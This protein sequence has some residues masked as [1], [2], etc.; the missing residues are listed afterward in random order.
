MRRNA[1]LFPSPGEIEFDCSCPDWA[2]M[3]KHIAA[4]LY[5][6][7]ARLDEDPTL[8]FTLRGV[9]TGDLIK[10]TVSS[11]AED[12]LRKV[13]RKS[14][15]IIEGADLSAAF[16]IEL[17]EETGTSPED[18]PAQVVLVDGRVR[19]AR[20]EKAGKNREQKNAASA[21][22]VK[23]PR[24]AAAKKNGVKRKA[25]AAVKAASKKQAAVRRSKR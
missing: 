2:S 21:Q 25:K 7:G 12:L 24:K 17:A 4:T 9:D 14:F 11:K 20:T 8:F 5:G 6:I 13:S 22:Q 18:V 3:C 1:G 19:N 16:G 10:R 23:R 15:R